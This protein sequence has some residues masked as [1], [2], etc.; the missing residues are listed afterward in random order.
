M[1]YISPIDSENISFVRRYETFSMLIK[2]V[3]STKNL[4]SGV[5]IDDMSSGGLS[6]TIFPIIKTLIPVF[7]FMP[8]NVSKNDFLKL[9][10]KIGLV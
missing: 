8:N 1:Y 9:Y 4:T 5:K 10:Q 2:L 3:A 7:K 6:K